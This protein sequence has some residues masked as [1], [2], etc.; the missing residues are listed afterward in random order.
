[1]AYRTAFDFIKLDQR[2][3]LSKPRLSGV[4]MVSD[5]QTG[6]SA[7]TD[8]MDTV[9]NYVDMFKI[10][11]GTSRLFP[12]SHLKKKLSILKQ[13]DV[14]PFLGGQFQEYAFHTNGL[15]IM[16]RHIGEANELGFEIV[17]VS[18]N[19]VPLSQDIKKTIFDLIYENGMTPV[20]EVGNKQN[21]TEP[22]KIVDEIQLMLELG[23]KWALVEAAELMPNGIANET[24][25]LELQ[26]NVD[27]TKCIFELATPR[28]G[29]T[30]VQIYA[31]KKFLIKTFG[32]DVNLGNVTTELVMETEATRLGLGTAGPL[33]Y[34]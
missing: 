3:S 30:T 10:A 31:G 20:A 16:D 4:T 14:K 32:P 34:L 5:Y 17:E 8:L 22:T 9:G 27:I 6:L 7:L 13:N 24:L 18:D 15:K 23:A 28:I 25:I 1:M 11:T 19:I 12:K 21:T 26:K 29:S 2:R 33:D